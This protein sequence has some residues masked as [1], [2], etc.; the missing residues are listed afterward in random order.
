[1]V[2]ARI[3]KA[4]NRR[5]RRSKRTYC[6]VRPLLP[7]LSEKTMINSFCGPVFPVAERVSSTSLTLGVSRGGLNRGKGVST[8]RRFTWL[9][10]AMAVATFFIASVLS[11]PADARV[12]EQ[13]NGKTKTSQFIKRT[14]ASPSSNARSASHTG[15][16]Q[17]SSRKSGV[18]KTQ[19]TPQ[20]T[21]RVSAQQ[22]PKTKVAY[23]ASSA[24]SGKERT[25]IAHAKPSNAKRSHDHKESVS[26]KTYQKTKRS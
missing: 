2:V 20:P 16:K 10:R 13:K 14:N 9:V 4:R 15:I 17:N 22:S 6:P 23:A 3:L 18:I 8:R 1:M 26:R 11:G 5:M 7:L 21:R 12:P 24:R 25:K 19:S